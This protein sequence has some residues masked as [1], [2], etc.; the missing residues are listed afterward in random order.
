MK[1]R[2]KY[3]PRGF[4]LIEL[5][6]ALTGGLFFAMFTF[7]MTRDISRFFQNEAMLSD[8]NMG[9]L[10]GFQRLRNDISRAGFMA[11][12]NLRF[13]P[14]RCPAPLPANTLNGIN[15][16]GYDANPELKRLALL[17]VDSG[18][19]TAS[20]TSTI[21]P[22]RLTLYG[23]YK[24]SESF[25][26]RA[27][28]PAVGG[29]IGLVLESESQALLRLGYDQTNATTAAALLAEI[30]PVNSIIR[31]VDDTGKQQYALV[32]NTSVATFG[33]YPAGKPQV[34]LS[35]GASVPSIISRGDSNSLCGPKANWTNVR[36]NPVNIIQYELDD[37]STTS[38]YNLFYQNEEPTSLVPVSLVRREL[39]AV[40][41][42]LN[43]SEEPISDYAVDFKVGLIVVEDVNTRTIKTIPA[44]SND[45]DGYG[46]PISGVDVSLSVRSR[47]GDRFGD[48][49]DANVASG[50]YRI[51]LKQ[52]SGSGTS[53]ETI[54]F[55]RVRTLR[56]QIATRNSRNALW[57]Y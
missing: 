2:Q 37:L 43:N 27:K 36:V 49:D 28:D 47:V 4:T 52:A 8:A 9:V 7:M 12:P 45:L 6:V 20:A 16:A 34:L 56:A 29:G 41:L 39:S 15:N 11:S 22:D 10:T 14:K 1:I 21:T 46:D 25:S 24:T 19:S 13:D 3:S 33:T 40:G 38:P 31:V 55:A 54:S 50:L 32:S 44:G 30:F 35:T 23:N 57:A 48:I 51:P 5:M 17:R 42:T 53:E 18:A 26:V